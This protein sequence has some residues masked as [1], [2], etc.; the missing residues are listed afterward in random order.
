MAELKLTR[1]ELSR[2]QSLVIDS[3]D[4]RRGFLFR[5]TPFE[6]EAYAQDFDCL[7]VELKERDALY[8][9]LSKMWSEAASLEANELAAMDKPPS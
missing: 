4:Q 5:L 6:K 2:L 9:K 7:Y 3:A 1:M 8:E